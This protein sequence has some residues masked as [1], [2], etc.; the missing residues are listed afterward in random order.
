MLV[1]GWLFSN[2]L[3]KSWF[4]GGWLFVRGGGVAVG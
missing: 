4:F 2:R 3:G 1:L